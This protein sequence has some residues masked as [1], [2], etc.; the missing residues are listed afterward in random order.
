MGETYA[1]AAV[2][3]HN[4]D[5]DICDTCICVGSDMA[6]LLNLVIDSRRRGCKVYLTGMSDHFRKIFGLV[7]LTKYA[8]IVGSVAE[9]KNEPD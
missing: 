2:V 8:A 9:I 4:C 5:T 3:T 7:G 6:I 1:K